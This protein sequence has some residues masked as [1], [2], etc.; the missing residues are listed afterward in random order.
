LENRKPDSERDEIAQRERETPARA[1]ERERDY[2]EWKKFSCRGAWK[3]DS[4]G[5]LLPGPRRQDVGFQ[6]WGLGCC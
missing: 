5:K 6:V 3:R 4:H 1:R 2:F